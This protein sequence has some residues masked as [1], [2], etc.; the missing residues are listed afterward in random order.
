M[1]W[2]FIAVVIR[3][4]EQRAVEYRPKYAYAITTA[5]WNY[6]EVSVQPTS[7]DLPIIYRCFFSMLQPSHKTSGYWNRVALRCKVESQHSGFGSPRKDG[8]N[9]NPLRRKGAVL[10]RDGCKRCFFLSFM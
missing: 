4:A 8:R 9:C 7:F 1:F 2:R 3:P 10:V 6:T 5:S